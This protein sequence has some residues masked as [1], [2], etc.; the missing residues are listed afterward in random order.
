MT[1][2][3]AAGG[4]DEKEAAII[5][6][7]RKTFLAQ[8]F[9]GASM[10]TIALVAGVSKRT[11]Y[12]RF[13]SKEELFA[14]AILQT[15]QHI[16]PVDVDTIEASLPPEAFIREMA[17]RF[18]RGIL[19]PEALAL[20]R[21]AAFEAPRKPALGKS[22]LTHGP[23]WVVK[24]CAPMLERLVAR[25]A[26]KIDNSERAIWQLGALITEPLYTDVIM[27]DPPTDLDA[28][29]DRQIDSAIK[30]FLKL[31]GA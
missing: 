30:A 7:A 19:E 15:C 21:I 8:G 27:G 10:D 26:L 29:I 1:K 22:Y 3:A 5:D 31:Y 4:A 24:V 20:R 25:G 11:V 17:T 2:I 6:A 18:L 9:D 13:R 16:L 28:A 23:R 14:A 12:N